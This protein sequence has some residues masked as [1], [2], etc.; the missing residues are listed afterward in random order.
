M[1]LA[2]APCPL[3]MFHDH[4]HGGRLMQH[5]QLAVGF[6]TGTRI[7]VDPSIDENDAVVNMSNQLSDIPGEATFPLKTE[8]EIFWESIVFSALFFL[9][10][11]WGHA[12]IPR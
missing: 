5:S 7:A 4:G 6:V 8:E 9:N 2:S 1:T 3:G 11:S 10:G 12:Q